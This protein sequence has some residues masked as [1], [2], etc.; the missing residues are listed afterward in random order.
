MLGE[1]TSDVLSEIGYS[2]SEIETLIESGAVSGVVN[3]D[4]SDR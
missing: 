3:P 1:H 4:L 2:S